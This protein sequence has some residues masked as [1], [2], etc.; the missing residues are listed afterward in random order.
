MVG[1][2]HELTGVGRAACD[3]MLAQSGDDADV[4]PA[5][6][7]DVHTDARAVRVP[8]RQAGA[9]VSSQADDRALLF[10]ASGAVRGVHM[11]CDAPSAG[12]EVLEAE[13]AALVGGRLL[14]L[15]GVRVGE[16]ARGRCR[17]AIAAQ[18]DA[19]QHRRAGQAERGL[20]L[21]RR[22][23]HLLPDPLAA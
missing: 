6:V 11:A 20:R 3:A 22:Q 17:R 23:R 15:A 2:L 5:A 8:Q 1:T 10:G 9:F 13:P 21:V 19:R 12:R 14:G 7:D 4:A 18:H 16:D